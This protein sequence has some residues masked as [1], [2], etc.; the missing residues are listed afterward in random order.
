MP[1]HLQLI[2]TSWGGRLLCCN[3]NV[4]FATIYA[5]ITSHPQPPQREG[6]TQSDN[7]IRNSDQSRRTNSKLNVWAQSSLSSSFSYRY[8]TK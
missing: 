6:E 7:L 2:I 5:L 3:R 4:M 1:G 8:T